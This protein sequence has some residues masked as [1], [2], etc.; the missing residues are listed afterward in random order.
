MDFWEVVRNR[1]M[2]RTYLERS[3]APDL[4]DR[5]VDAGLRAPSAGHS[6][7]VSIVVLE[8]PE[9]R[10]RFW[11][12]TAREGGP[13]PPGG[14]WDRLRQ[15]PV[16]LLPLAHK[17]TYLARYAEPDKAGLGMEAESGWTRPYWDIDAGFAVMSMLLAATDLGLGA[18]FFAVPYGVEAFLADLAVPG[19]HEPIGAITL[20]WPAPRDPPSASATRGRR[21]RDEAVHYGHWGVGRR[22]S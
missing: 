2:I 5:I 19:G 12:A 4:V 6:Q 1:R 22:P 20:G 7:G 10:D 3:V 16:V 13:P 15:A 8:A 9:H 14:R 21:A 17:Q 11:A 18:L